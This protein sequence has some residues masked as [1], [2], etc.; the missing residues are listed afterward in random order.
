M[1]SRT[2]VYALGGV[3]VLLV[4]VVLATGELPLQAQVGGKCADQ[5]KKEKKIIEGSAPTFEDAREVAPKK[6]GAAF[7]HGLAGTLA[8]PPGCERVTLTPSVTLKP[9]P[10]FVKKKNGRWQYKTLAECVATLTCKPQ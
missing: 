3:A 8:C 6:D 9:F 7:C 1:Y 10:A 2:I 4:G 5:E